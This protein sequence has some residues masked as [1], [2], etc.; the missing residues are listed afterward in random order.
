MTNVIEF[1]QQISQESTIEQQFAFVAEIADCQ[2]P[3]HIPFLEVRPD[4]R[5][6]SV[7]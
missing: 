6:G 5:S 7:K 2:V 1:E 4:L 3:T